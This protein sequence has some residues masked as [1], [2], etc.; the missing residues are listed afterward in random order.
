MRRRRDLRASSR[1]EMPV[2]L[3]RSS[4]RATPS[5]STHRFRRVEIRPTRRDH[6]HAKVSKTRDSSEHL[7]HRRACSNQS[8]SW[9]RGLRVRLEGRPDLT[10]ESPVQPCRV[11]PSCSDV[12]PRRPGVHRVRR[13]HHRREARMVEDGRRLRAPT[14]RRCWY[15]RRAR[16]QPRSRVHRA[17]GLGARSLGGMGHLADRGAVIPSHGGRLFTRSRPRS[18]ACPGRHR[19]TRSR[20]RTSCSCRRRR[21][22]R[23]P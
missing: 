23:A 1:W 21:P 7:A 13:G 10:K 14:S 6:Q 2:P 15:H 9:H 22:R 19:P 20:G 16:H 11:R 8:N 17:V 18:R 5:I 4:R 3:R 12:A